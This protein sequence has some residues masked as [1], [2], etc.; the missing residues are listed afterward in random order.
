MNKKLKGALTIVA[1]VSAV[2]GVGILVKKTKFSFHKEVCKTLEKEVPNKDI[3]NG[4]VKGMS[5]SMI[6]GPKTT[7]N[8]NASA[9]A[10]LSITLQPRVEISDVFNV[11]IR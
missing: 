9:S 6:E 1:A 10:R 11:K 2:V 8:A 5:K 3:C 4:D 7:A